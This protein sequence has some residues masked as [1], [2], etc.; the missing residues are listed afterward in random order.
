MNIRNPVGYLLNHHA[1]AQAGGGGGDWVPGPGLNYRLAGNGLYAE[2]S[3]PLLR[4]RVALHQGTVKG[5]EECREELELPMGPIPVGLF[6][7]GLEW[8]MR[9]PA[10]ERFFALAQTGE[11][12]S[13]VM[14]EQEG[15]AS[16][17]TYQPVEGTVAE[18]HSH[19]AMRAFFSNTDDRDEQGFAIY[20]V[21]GK[22]N[23]AR[24]QLAL[25]LGIYGHFGPAPWDLAFDG[26]PG[27]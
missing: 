15:T 25:R 22:L 10:Q 9:E 12:Y 4:G 6:E 27:V 11:G 24:P 14:P 19:G 7:T 16:S 17:L 21:I 26:R 5:L 13:L 20:G 2:A 18:F 23:T 8:M 1:P 3:T